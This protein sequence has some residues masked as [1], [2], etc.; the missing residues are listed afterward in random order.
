MCQ[1]VVV[2]F[3]VMKTNVLSEMYSTI[4]RKFTRILRIF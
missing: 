1:K 2:A 4:I 3:T